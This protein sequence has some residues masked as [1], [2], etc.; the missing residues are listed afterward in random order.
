MV[1]A[2]FSEDIVTVFLGSKWSGAV[3]LFRL[4]SPTVFTLAL[5]N[6]LTWL[7]LA[8]GQPDRSLR[9]ALVT[10]PVVIAGYVIGLGAGPGGVAAG[11]SVATLLL[12]VPT[13]LW[14]TRGTLVTAV[15]ILKVI[16]RPLLSVVAAA[17][18]TWAVW[19][20]IR[21][22]AAPL[23]R[24][25]ASSTLFLGVYAFLLFFVMGQKNLY[26]V[27]LRQIGIWPGCKMH[28]ERESQQ[29]SG[30]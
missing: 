29:H 13:I 15:D 26:F 22:L 2:L 11:F 19:G 6:P 27:L 14:A 3:P 4:L 10:S 18:A 7:L 30:A 28:Q 8:I 20:F 17:A 21:P 16:A 1:C 12:T 24:L 23:L 9:I 5:V 25:T